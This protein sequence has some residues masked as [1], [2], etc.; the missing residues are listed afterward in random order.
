MYNYITANAL[1]M[2][3]RNFGLTICQ[4]PADPELLNLVYR[5]SCVGSWGIK[6]ARIDEIRAK[7]DEIMELMK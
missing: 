1:N 5:G 3:Q 7:A 6:T 4:A 2:Q